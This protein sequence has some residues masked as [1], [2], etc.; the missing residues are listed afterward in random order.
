MITVFDYLDYRNF[1]KDFY[2]FSKG[3]NSYFS[4]RYFARKLDIDPGYLVKVLQGKYHLTL[5]KVSLVAKVCDF[6]K[7]EKQYFS[8]LIKFN[9][10][11]NEQDVKLYFEKLLSYKEVKAKSTLASQ[12]KF[13]TKWYYSA[14]RSLLG[15]YDF[16]GD[17]E[18]LGSMLSPTITA[19]D[20]REAVDL[21]LELNLIEYTDAG[22]LVLQ[23]ANITTGNEWRSIAIRQFQ[24][25]TI[26]LAGES[27]ER[28]D[29]SLR[30]ISTLTAAISR[31]NLDDLKDIIKEFRTTMVN[32]IDKIEEPD[33]V[34]QL[35]IQLIPMSDKKEGK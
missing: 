14:V 9:K 30:D 21:L 12:Y 17:Y 2:S 28:H 32:Y 19:R 8:T 24:K 3:S 18:K 23:D 20:A 5:E 15:F 4:Y 7:T 22:K 13:Y 1:L 33:S 6:S 29:A 26:K 27:L 31:E 35:N 11:K 10:A 25:E 34:Y 16:D